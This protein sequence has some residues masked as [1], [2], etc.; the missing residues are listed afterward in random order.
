MKKIEKFFKKLLLLGLLLFIKKRTH[1]KD[2][3]TI[4]KDSKILFIRLNRIGDALVSTPLIDL[5]KK[6]IGSKI[7]VLADRKNYFVFRNNPNIDE[8][9]VFP[10]G[11]KAFNYVK[12]FIKKNDINVLV[13]LHDDVSTT[14]SIIT[15]ISDCNYKFGL[16]KS[17][18]QLYTHTINRIDSSKNHVIDRILELSKLFG[19]NYSKD[20]IKIGY[21]PKEENIFFAKEFINKTFSKKR[22]LLGVNISAGSDARFWGVESFQKLLT[23]LSKYPVDVLLFADSKDFDKANLIAEKYLIYPVTKDFDKF[24]AGIL[25]IDMLFSPDTSAIH[26]V[27]IKRIP[28]F[29]LYV[30]YK[31]DDMIWSPYNTDFNCIITEESNLSNVSFEEVKKKF[32]PFLE[33]HLNAKRNSEL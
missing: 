4:N 23:E 25:E 14:V 32:I 6:K 8:I 5:V 12:K 18:Y 31:T 13:D 1:N 27:S 2:L 24:A 16:T 17:N 10:K 11:I 22:F 28:V 20:E 15:A 30:K 7:Y 29:G 9:I 33:K 3:P 26:I 19:F 21:Y